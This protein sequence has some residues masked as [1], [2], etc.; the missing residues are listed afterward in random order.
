MMK[1]IKVDIVSDIVCPWCAVGYFR[2]KQAAEDLAA[3]VE[4]HWHPF[5]LNPQMP[6]GGQNLREHLAQKYGTSLNG[7]IEARKRITELGAQVGFQFNYF[8]EMK[9]YNTIRAHQIL[10][11]SRKYGLQMPLK[12]QLFRDY[13]TNGKEMD[14]DTILKRS[15]VQTGL[16]EHETEQVL[17]ENLYYAD[18]K[19]EIDDY[20][21]KGITGVPAFIF[22]E[23]HLVTGAQETD[24]FKQIL[25]ELSQPQ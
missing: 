9:M 16:P 23:K 2:F 14:S 6:P 8:D 10:H 22:N 24:T 19:N 15:A 21:F 12:L 5:E 7:S 18:V 17:R 11:F 13:F 3:D 4:V 1:A 20:R 25:K